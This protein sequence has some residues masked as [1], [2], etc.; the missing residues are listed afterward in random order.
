MLEVCLLLLVFVASASCY[1]IPLLLFKPLKLYKKLQLCVRSKSS[2]AQGSGVGT[3][4]TP[5]V[6]AAAVAT[7]TTV[8]AP[9]TTATTT[10]AAAAAVLDVRP[11]RPLV[12][13][14]QFRR[15]RLLGFSHDL[16][17]VAPQVLVLFGEERDRRPRGATTAGSADPVDVVLN[18]TR[19]VEVDDVS[20]PLDI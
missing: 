3:G 6:A 18:V 1:F 15:H 4:L 2:V 20:D 16:A 12:E 10:A 11:P 5:A 14:L 8:A 17:Q 7:A 13:P 19:H 9:A